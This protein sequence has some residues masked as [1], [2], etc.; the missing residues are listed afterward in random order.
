MKKFLLTLAALLMV[1]TVCAEEYWYI[2]DF[3]V[4]QDQLGTNNQRLNVKAHYDYYVSAVQA[5]FTM[6]EGMSIRTYRAGSDMTMTG[7]DDLGDPITSTP[8]LQ[9]LPDYINNL[10]IASM[11]S[12]YDE[13]GNLLGAFHWAPGDYDQMIQIVVIID[14][15]FAGGE[16]TVQTEPSSSGWAD[17]SMDCPKGQINIH[18]CNVTVEGAEPPV[19]TPAPEIIVTAGENAYTFEAVG[20]GV[21][22][23]LR[24]GVEVENPYTVE[25]TTEDQIVK[26]TATAHVEGQTDGSVYGEY[27]VPALEVVTPVDPSGEIIISDPDEN[28]VVTITYT[29]DEDDV[30][31]TV[32]VN[33]EEVELG[34]D[35][36]ITVGEGESEI[37]VVVGGEGYNDLTEG[38]TV[39]YT[40]PEPPQ[41]QDLTGEI[42]VSEPTEDGLVTITYTGDE[43]VT[44]TVN[45]E[46]YN[47]EEIQLVEGENA[48]DVVVS[49]EGYNDLTGTFTVTWT[50]PEPPQPEPTPTP[51]ISYE[52]NDE[53]VVITVTGEGELHVYVDGVEVENP[54]TIERG[55]TDVVVVVTATAQ[56]EGQLI[57]ETA[58][59]E[60]TIPAISEEPQDPHATGVW[61][62]FFDK[63]GEEVWY[64]MAPGY[65]DPTPYG[66]DL[67][68][69]KGIYGFPTD[70]EWPNVDFY[71]VINGQNYGPEVYDELIDP[72]EYGDASM[73]EL[74]AGDEHFAVPT[75]YWY[76]IGVF[77]D[78]E[79]GIMYL[80]IS[81]G[82]FTDVDELNAGKTV[83][84]VR[85]F[86]LAGQEMQE[87]NGVTIIVTNY[88]D[89]TTSVAKV[90]K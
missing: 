41:P 56:A 9:F 21:V 20:E 62:V 90:M 61:V 34:E 83:A 51:E 67:S 54:Y 43:D 16:I 74:F 73:H 25:R 57:S 23:L 87:A 8:E 5:T 28:G 18:T 36:T 84:N 53:A 70:E 78:R 47:G 68:L 69:N 32:T 52:V 75:G 71:L 4:T 55:A 26:L 65:G 72:E 35:G 6:P 11:A 63:N 12:C 14:E 89:G 19:V 29:G 40:V 7:L 49:A 27:L 77:T 33:G 10:I 24:E 80:Q 39:T 38:K 59:M 64:P 81:K 22:T 50:V 58:T 48:F 88:T 3:Q 37:V 60:I 86:N 85:Y 15:N 79:T 76:S 46:E 42:V 31:I 13:D 66:V 45:G 17:G 44:I 30:T 2:E 1:G 82:P